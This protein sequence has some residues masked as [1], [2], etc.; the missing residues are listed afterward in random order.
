MAL[1]EIFAEVLGEATSV[2]PDQSTVKWTIDSLS[3]RF[4]SAA[5]RGE[6]PDVE[7]AF[8]AHITQDD[9]L[10][11]D[12]MPAVLRYHDLD[13]EE[14]EDGIQVIINAATGARVGDRDYFRALAMAAALALTGDPNWQLAS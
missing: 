1:D 10:F 9:V 2:E 6:V 8:D 11:V 14:T 7:W 12:P 13:L 3:S 5:L 4:R